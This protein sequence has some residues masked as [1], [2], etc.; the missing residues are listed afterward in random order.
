MQNKFAS[1]VEDYYNGFRCFDKFKLNTIALYDKHCSEYMSTL[2]PYI[3]IV[4][5]EGVK[6]IKVG[7]VFCDK[8][9]QE[10]CDWLFLKYKCDIA[11]AVL[12]N[13]KR[14]SVRRNTNVSNVDV[15]RFTQRIANGGG[16]E[17]AAG[18]TLTDEFVEF[19]KMLKPIL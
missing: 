10:C 5:F 1:F 11:I 9:V 13:Q 7:S 2:S 17:A 6:N 4:D 18:G 16:H 12:M 8:F 3:G 19:T 15:S 14:I